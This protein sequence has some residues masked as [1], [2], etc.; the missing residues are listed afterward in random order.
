MRRLVM[1]QR[2]LTPPTSYGITERYSSL[3]EALAH[4]G[5]LEGS[6]FLFDN[7][8]NVE[9]R[10]DEIPSL[11]KEFGL[12]LI[13]VS[14]LDHK[15][16]TIFEFGSGPLF[17]PA[18]SRSTRRTTPQRKQS[19]QNWIQRAFTR[20]WSTVHVLRR[21]DVLVID[22]AGAKRLDDDDRVVPIRE[23]LVQ[24]LTPVVQ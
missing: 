9:M 16:N 1:C 22:L 20:S 18:F 6:E 10:T 4:F 14:T 5:K 19:F 13:D 23:H 15:K 21:E 17:T 24:L 3:P 7:P 8:S 2:G 12:T 11:L